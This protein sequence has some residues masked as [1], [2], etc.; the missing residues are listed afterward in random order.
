M[1]PGFTGWSRA[2]ISG[3]PEARGSDRALASSGCAQRF[4]ASG[5]YQSAIW[6]PCCSG[7]TGDANMSF[8][9]GRSREGCAEIFRQEK[10][11]E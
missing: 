3:C 11:H 6:I 5:Y 9:T 7:F 10:D 1:D 8:E 4:L 2:S